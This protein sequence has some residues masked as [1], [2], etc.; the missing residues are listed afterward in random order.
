MSIRYLLIL[1]FALFYACETE[2]EL[3]IPPPEPRLSLNC[4]LIANQNIEI[5]ISKSRYVL[6]AEEELITN[7]EVN[8][9][10]DNKLLGKIEH[11]SAGFY[12][13]KTLKAEAGKQYSI[14]VYV[15]GFDTLKATTT[16]PKD[17]VLDSI[18]VE[19]FVGKSEKGELTSMITL[20]FENKHQYYQHH[21][22]AIVDS[23]DFFGA[24]SFWAYYSYDAAIMEEREQGSKIFRGKLL[25]ANHASLHLYY[26]DPTTADFLFM[27]D[28]IN[29]TLYAQIYALSEE[30]YLHKKSLWNYY[31]SNTAIWNNIPHVYSNI[32]NGYGIFAGM[33]YSNVISQRFLKEIVR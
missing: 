5:Y 17:I 29:F 9:Y 24:I 20:F 8:I 33:S 27:Q 10:S 16:V 6:D 4:F 31:G 14:K 26:V 25:P 21:C 7:A 19:R 3:D 12:R 22:S 28:T 30:L 32:E 13:S 18:N 15:A 23:I 11:D 1:L 2:T